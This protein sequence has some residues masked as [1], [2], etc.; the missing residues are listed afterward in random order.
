MLTVI[1]YIIFV[2]MER[3]SLESQKEFRFALILHDFAF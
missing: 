1:Y 2:K 3:F